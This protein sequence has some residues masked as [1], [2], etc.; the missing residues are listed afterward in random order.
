MSGGHDG[1]RD[2]LRCG[3]CKVKGR[4]PAGQGRGFPGEV[5][6]ADSWGMAPA[7][8]GDRAL[9][10]QAREVVLR[11]AALPGRLCQR[12]GV[13][14]FFCEEQLQFA[15]ELVDERPGLYGRGQAIV[16]ISALPPAGKELGAGHG[17]V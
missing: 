4:A 9:A 16:I 8:V 1:P 10:H 14:L 15:E 11:I 7:R 5:F 17:S 3:T 13:L 2:L 12:E 6:S